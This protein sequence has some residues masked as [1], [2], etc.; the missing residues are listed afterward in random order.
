MTRNIFVVNIFLILMFNDT[1]PLFIFKQNLLASMILCHRTMS[2]LVSEVMFY[3]TTEQFQMKFGDVCNI[4][5]FRI[6]KLIQ[7]T[8]ALVY[9]LAIS[10]DFF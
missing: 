2:S 7:L 3:I 6:V 8:S 1:T 10:D 5:E 4:V 9:N